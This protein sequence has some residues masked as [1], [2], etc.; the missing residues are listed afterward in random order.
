MGNIDIFITAFKDFKE[1][2]TDKR[3]KIVC[4]KDYNY[5]GKLEWYKD[6]VGDNISDMNWFFNE[7]TTFY[8]VWK[9][10]EM[11]DYVG[12]CSYRRYFDFFDDIDS[13]ENK[14]KEYDIILP[15][16]TELK[17]F[18]N[19]KD[20][21]DKC[22]NLD[23]LILLCN[24]INI[25]YPSYNDSIDFMLNHDKIYANN[26]FIMKRDDFVK[27]CEFVFEIFDEF[28]NIRGF[29]TYED[30]CKYIKNNS[31]KYI[32]NKG[33]T[34]KI[35]YQSRLGGFLAERLFT[36]YVHHNF[37]NIYE[38][39]MFFSE[40]KKIEIRFENFVIKN[41]EKIKI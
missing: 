36:V 30:I 33:Y 2:V 15:C 20:H 31:E 29:K 23:D 18:I 37:K 17:P 10:Y 8:W 6:N 7:L 9:N 32:K 14:L 28:L 19:N 5:N 27:Y 34:P 26:M 41:G 11:K 40:D 21:Y 22:H 38:H 39:K 13:I 35:E 1:Y 4:V 24:I 3:Y 25:K 12:M 16:Q